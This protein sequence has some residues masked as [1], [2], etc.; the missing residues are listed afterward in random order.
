VARVAAPTLTEQG[1][2]GTT[3]FVVNLP[4][5]VNAGEVLVMAVGSGGGVVSAP[6]G[7]TLIGGANQA[8]ADSCYGFYRVATGAE[9][10]TTVTLTVA[11]GRAT[12]II[13]RYSGVDTSTPIDVAATTGQ[14]TGVGST[15]V[16]ASQTTVTNNAFLVS[17]CCGNA[18]TGLTWTQPGG[19]VTPT[20]STSGAGALAGKGA[21]YS[22]GVTV[23]PAA[24]TGT[25]TWTWSSSGL[26]M[27]GW[28]A[29]LRPA[30]P[31]VGLSFLT[32]AFASAR[33][34]YEV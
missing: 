2:A 26:Q 4:A 31:P 5:T 11:A 20:T 12:G 1:T 6:A 33:A 3:S 34:V 15:C 18:A 8:A 13:T 25:V 9:G 27:N 32:N 17:A 14:N 19:F 30:A 21:A 10:G 23:S 28:L 24:A 16:I 22:D 7:W 29:A